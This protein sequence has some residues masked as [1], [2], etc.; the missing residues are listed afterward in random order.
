[1]LIIMIIIILES[2]LCTYE[3]K[4]ELGE[5]RLTVRTYE[6]EYYYIDKFD[7]SIEQSQPM[8]V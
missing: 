4:E 5:T 6:L 8:Y 3:R 2:I 7:Q 1:M